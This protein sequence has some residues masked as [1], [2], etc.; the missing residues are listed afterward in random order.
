MFRGKK[1]HP[2]PS[3]SYD[4]DASYKVSHEGKCELEI[5]LN[6]SVFCRYLMLFLRIIHQSNGQR[7]LRDP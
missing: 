2:H 4:T 3:T 5:L 1:K 6:V 7:S